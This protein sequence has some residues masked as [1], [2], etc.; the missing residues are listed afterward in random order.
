MQEIYQVSYDI[1]KEN[2]LKREL[3]GLLAASQSTRCDN[4]FLL[5]DYEHRTIEVSGK[6]I[7][8]VPV[9]EWLLNAAE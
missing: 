4:L 3:R 6:T 5:T 7:K 1:S 9:Y 2:T 8:V